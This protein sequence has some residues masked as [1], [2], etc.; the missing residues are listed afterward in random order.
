MRFVLALGALTCLAGCASL[1]EVFNGPP[2]T[3]RADVLGLDDPL[4]TSATVQTPS[5]NTTWSLWGHGGA[6]PSLRAFVVKSAET[7]AGLDSLGLAY[8]NGVA[9]QLY[10]QI[11]APEPMRWSSVRYLVG[12]E[13]QT[14][15]AQVVGTDVSCTSGRCAHYEDVVATLSRADLDALAASDSA[16]TFRLVSG[17]SADKADVP[18]PVIELRS[19]LTTVDSVQAVVGTLRR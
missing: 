12:D 18:M 9:Y 19:F 14:R 11:N 6:N 3:N 5:F 15:D 2:S 16:A 4:E 17:L 13:L 8:E 1:N 7:A 10:V